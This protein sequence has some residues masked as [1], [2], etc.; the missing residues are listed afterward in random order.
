MTRSRYDYG[1]E[2][3]ATQDF[4]P[5]TDNSYDLGST[6]Y[7]WKDLYVDGTAAIDSLVADTADINGGT[8]DGVTIGTN[9]AC[10]DLRVDNV[11]VDGNTISTTAAG[12][13]I[14]LPNASSITVVGDAGSTSHSLAANDDL[15]VSGKLEVDG[16]SYLD[17]TVSLGGTTSL[18]GVA[19][20]YS[21][22]LFYGGSGASITVY[23]VTEEVTIPVGEGNTPVVTSSSN[24]APANSI[25]KAVAVRVTQAPGGGATVVS[26]GRTNGG[27]TDEFIDDISTAVNTTGNSV[28]N[29]DGALVAEDMWN[30]S[31]DTFDVTTDA[32]VTDS[33][34][35]IRIVVWYEQITSPTS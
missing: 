18:N 20:A 29:N 32:D 34:M 25:I 22:F 14:L 8:I 33:D 1:S 9:A 2:G 11:K 16:A 35:K 31:A 28:A 24:L 4:I 19:S 12:N 3:S 15:F 10:T 5:D 17:G 27:N 6:T 21:T 30:A 26:V 23:R 7:E 13:L